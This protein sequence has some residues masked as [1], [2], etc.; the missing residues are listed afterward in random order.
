MSCKLPNATRDAFLAGWPTASTSV[1]GGS[2]TVFPTA[3][4]GWARSLLH[5]A[6]V[7]WPSS[8]LSAGSPGPRRGRGP[9][10]RPRAQLPAA[11]GGLDPESDPN[12]SSGWEEAEPAQLS[13]APRP[14]GASPRPEARTAAARTRPAARA[15]AP[16]PRARAAV[17]APRSPVMASERLPSRPACLLVASGAAEGEAREGGVGAASAPARA[18][19]RWR[20]ARGGARCGLAS[21]PG[22]RPGTRWGTVPGPC[23]ARA[24]PPGSVP[25]EGASGAGRPGPAPRAPLLGRGLGCS[26]PAVGGAGRLGLRKEVDR[27]G[28]G[29]PRRVPGS[30]SGA[31]LRPDFSCCP[32]GR[33]SEGSGSRGR[34]VLSP[35][36][37]P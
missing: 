1:S 5:A 12:S 22:R 6:A 24:A 30:R 13:P 32:R 28:G 20:A 35:R 29:A 4:G 21:A 14:R 37:G 36:R 11:G 17:P 27:R 16:P 7:P 2:G 3:S 18:E 10:P 26:G 23:G 15:R 25:G 19:L 31:C 8:D 34:S 9:G 33:G